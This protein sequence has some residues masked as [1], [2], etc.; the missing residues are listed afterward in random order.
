MSM[1]V[2]L[3]L[4][5][6]ALVALVALASACSSAPPPSPKLIARCTQLYALWF[7]YEQHPTYHHTGQRARAELALYDCQNGNYESGI[8]ELERLLRRGRL[9]I[10]PETASG[11]AT[12]TYD[13]IAREPAKPRGRLFIIRAALRACALT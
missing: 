1:Q 10:P 12:A 6:V 5:S 11:A 9:P 4:R 3:G 2:H 8:Q 13:G 7:R